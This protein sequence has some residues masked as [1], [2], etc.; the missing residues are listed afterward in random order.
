M[1]SIK[2]QAAAQ[3]QQYINAAIQQ[4]T[5]AGGAASN[6]IATV[7]NEQIQNDTSFQNALAE[8]FGALGGNLGS[9]IPQKQAT[10]A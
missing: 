6:N 8:A 9:L 2:E 5:S 4:A 10:A 7:A 1:Q 3:Q